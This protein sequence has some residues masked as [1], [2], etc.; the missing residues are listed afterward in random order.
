MMYELNV[1][2][3]WMNY[4][5]GEWVDSSDKIEI[6][7][8]AT[9]EVIAAVA[10]A[11]RGE[12][13]RA[14]VAARESFERSGWR[15]LRP[16]ERGRKVM[17]MGRYLRDHLDEIARVLCFDSGKPLAQAVTEV[18]GAARYFEFYGSHA[19][20]FEGRSIPLGERYFDFTVYEPFGVTAH[21]IPWNYPLEMGARS[22]SAALATGNTVVIKSPELDP[23]SV[24]Y[25]A[26]A[27]EAVGLPAGA[28]N[29]LCGYG[30]EAG[31]ALVSHPDVDQIVFTG[32]VA[33]GQSICMRRPT[34]WFRP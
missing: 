3:P 22:A 21:V 25:L 33:T 7:D 28:L 6:R 34:R 10:K 15:G 30:E 18:E 26:D 20:K 9:G 19:D 1:K 31:A 11:R 27:A 32:S 13:D 24:Y 4:I 8:P 29:I 2:R 5:G 23:L 17:G 14:V 12:V 16:I